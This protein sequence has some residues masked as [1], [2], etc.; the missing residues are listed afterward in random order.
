M[1]TLE[2]QFITATNNAK[3][4]KTK[5]TNDEMLCLYKYYKQASVGKCNTTAPWAFNVVDSAK[6]S[7]W[8]S[9]G[10]MTKEEAMKS[11]IKLVTEL[12]HK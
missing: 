2:N 7:A 4:L 10:N 1:S 11:Y 8:N 5:P 9:L 12:Q 3:T 6:W